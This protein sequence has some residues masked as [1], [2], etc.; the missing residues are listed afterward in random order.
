V[1]NSDDIRHWV[2]ERIA[3]LEARRDEL[4]SRFEALD[5]GDGD[6]DDARERA[7]R[8]LHFARLARTRSMKAHAEAARIHE[9]AARLHE[10]MVQAGIGESDW[11]HRRAAHHRRMAAGER[12]SAEEEMSGRPTSPVSPGQG[13]RYDRP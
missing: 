12:R 13:M 8:A 4:N 7:G 10:R 6:M 9:E 2:R 1:A 11:H 5:A 3:E